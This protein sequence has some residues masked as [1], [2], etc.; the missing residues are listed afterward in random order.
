[1]SDLPKVVAISGGIGGAKLALGL[2]RI[3]PA[4]ALMVVC[5]TGDDF[6]HLGLCISPDLD[7]VLY[8]LAGVANRQTGWGRADESWNFMTAVKEL[9]GETWFQLGDRDLATHVER[10]RRCR[11][12]ESLT[13]ISRDFCR[14]LGVRADIVPMCDQPVRTMV[15]TEKDGVLPFQ[16]YFVERRSAPKVAGFDF[17][18]VSEASLSADVLAALQR[19]DLDSVVICPSNPF[20]SID[21]I[22]AVP[23]MRDAIQVCTAPVIAV[24]PIIGGQAVKGPTAKMMTELGQSICNLSIADHYRG[25]LDG[26]VI[27]EEDGEDAADI[28]LP[29][30]VTPTLMRSEDDKKNLAIKVLDFARTLRG[31]APTVV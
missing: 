12:G 11:A 19:P 3:L 29:C 20:I 28:D 18:G 5:N 17:A 16:R 10:T 15:A 2:Y 1:M 14:R 23:G 9:G 6:E 22:L 21:P 26:L 30:L 25:L 7:T 31:P 24:S 13:S 27:D 4:D 8:T